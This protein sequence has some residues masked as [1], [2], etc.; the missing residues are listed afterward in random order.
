MCVNIVFVVVTKTEMS[1]KLVSNTVT[2]ITN[3]L[4]L[5]LCLNYC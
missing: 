3:I 2:I 1:R 5:L 4:T